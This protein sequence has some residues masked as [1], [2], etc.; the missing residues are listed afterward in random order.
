MKAL[1]NVASTVR[2]GVAQG[3]AIK[4]PNILV[5]F[6][7]FRAFPQAELEAIQV[8]RVS[9]VNILHTFRKL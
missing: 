1:T 6:L 3:A 8:V 4:D 5:L 9:K 7:L 2:S